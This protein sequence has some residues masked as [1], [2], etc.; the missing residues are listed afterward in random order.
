MN[1]PGMTWRDAAFV[2][3]VAVLAVASLLVFPEV[4]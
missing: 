1:P 3:L 2:A 4:A